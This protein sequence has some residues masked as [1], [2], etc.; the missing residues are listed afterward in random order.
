MVKKQQQCEEA[1]Y[2]Y[3][4]NTINI[5]IIIVSRLCEMILM[6]RDN[7]DYND[8]MNIFFVLKSLFFVTVTAKQIYL[9]NM[10]ELGFAACLY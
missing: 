2:S 5:I 3:I 9:S 7:K 1:L 6:K 4:E 8:K 10:H